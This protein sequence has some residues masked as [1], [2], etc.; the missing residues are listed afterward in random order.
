MKRFKGKTALITG[1]G[2]GVGRQAALSFLKE[3]AN[4]VINDIDEN[5][6]LELKRLTKKDKDKVLILSTDIS[7][8]NDVKNML[9]SAIEKFVHIDYLINNAGVS[10]TKKMMEIENCDWDKVLD[11][12]VKGTF[13]VLK[14]VARSMIDNKIKG[15]IVNIASIAGEKGRPNFLAYSASKA[16][17]I[18]ITKSA[19]LEFADHGIRINSVSPGT[20]D[21]PMWDKV[22]DDI[23]KIQGGKKED[24]QKT[25]VEKIP[26]KRLAKPDDISDVILFLCSDE[27][28]F[29]TGQ[30]INVCGGLSIV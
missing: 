9:T 6:L 16:A 14:S 21:T 13:D 12:N 5:S 22:A 7:N 3:G 2:S 18:S 24:L 20:I 1:A 10:M 23:I 4:V 28:R 8:S 17:L 27:A 19:A 26:L 30:I 25:W 29:I 11:V 15:A